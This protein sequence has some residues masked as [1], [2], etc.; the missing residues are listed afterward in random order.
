MKPMGDDLPQYARKIVSDPGTKNGLYWPTQPDE[1]PSPLGELVAQAADEGYGA[2][3][4]AAGE[5]SRPY[6]GY[7]YVLLTK[8]G[9]HAEG[10]Q[11]DYEV[12]GKLI[13]GFAVVA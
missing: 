3:T 12:D 1:T 11:M 4:R 6:H 8:Q 9:P 10:G 2:T 13:G 7:R 5:A